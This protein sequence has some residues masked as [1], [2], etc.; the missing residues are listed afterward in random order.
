MMATLTDYELEVER[1]NGEVSKLED[2]NQEL[3]SE[4]D[5]LKGLLAEYLIINKDWQT[6]FEAWVK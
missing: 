4:L 2:A 1:L 5:D 3:T 6:E